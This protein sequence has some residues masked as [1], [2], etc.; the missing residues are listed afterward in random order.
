M[1]NRQ[2]PDKKFMYAFHIPQSEMMHYTWVPIV[3]NLFSGISTKAGVCS[4]IGLCSMLIS[5]VGGLYDIIFRRISAN[6][7][8]VASR[9]MTAAAQ[10][11]KLKSERVCRVF[12]LWLSVSHDYKDIHMP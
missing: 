6:I 5:A 12:L 9:Y 1:V 4:R 11:V 8:M 2:F 3:L 7:S 10:C